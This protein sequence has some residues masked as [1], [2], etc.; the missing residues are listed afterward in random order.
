MAV[1]ASVGGPV[2]AVVGAAIGA[3]AGGVA[4][5]GVAAAVD[6]SVEHQ[7]W[8]THFQSRPY[9]RD[10]AKY[11]EYRDAYRYGW[12]SR[13]KST[14]TWDTAATEIEQGWD[15]AREKSGL[16]W[17]DAKEAVHD[18]WN[19]VEKVIPGDADGDGR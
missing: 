13:A 17:E 14:S 7:Y 4:G 6:P 9:V 15:K 18:G 16:A 8:S 19:R 11:D 12:E 3:V 10:G 2:G 1:G 5:H